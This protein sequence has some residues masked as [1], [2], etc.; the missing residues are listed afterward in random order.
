MLMAMTTGARTDLPRAAELFHALSD[1]T[2]LSIP[3]EDG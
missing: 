3:L 2:R 1:R